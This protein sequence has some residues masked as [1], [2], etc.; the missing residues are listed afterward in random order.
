MSKADSGFESHATASSITEIEEQQEKIGDVRISSESMI[1]QV[2][3]STI[4][5]YY[6]TYIDIFTC[7]QCCSLLN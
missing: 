7:M 5:L 4:L 1:Y 2:S 6:S 3:I